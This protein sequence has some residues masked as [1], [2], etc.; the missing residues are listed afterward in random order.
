MPDEKDTAQAKLDSLPV[1]A[2]QRWRHFKG[3]EYEIMAVGLMEDTLKPLVV[4][5]NPI[6]DTV[7]ARTADNFLETVEREGKTF[8]RF[9][10]IV[11]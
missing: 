10:V 11:L 4:Y 9:E 1:R 2:G 5:K 3:G 7:W 8:P 6:K